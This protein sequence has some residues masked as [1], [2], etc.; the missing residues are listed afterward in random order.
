MP[1]DSG[2]KRLA[3]TPQYAKPRTA[4]TPVVPIKEA[5]LVSITLLAL[6]QW[7]S[8]CNAFTVKDSFNR[9][10]NTCGNGIPYVHFYETH[11]HTQLKNDFSYEE[12]TI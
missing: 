3:A 6:I 12:R 7:E 1:I 9:T 10:G 5:A 11:K 4:V 2:E 8:N